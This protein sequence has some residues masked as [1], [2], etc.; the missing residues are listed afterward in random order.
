MDKTQTNQDTSGI[1]LWLITWKAYDAMHANALASIDELG[2]CLSD[3]GI[4]ELLLHK[5]PSTINDLGSKLSLTSGSSTQAVDRLESRGLVRREPSKTDRRAKVVH[6]TA[7]GRQL[8]EESF[9]RHEKDMERACDELTGEER[10]ELIRLLK[11]LGKHAQSLL[12][13]KGP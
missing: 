6:L 3:F 5:G 8:I 10:A 7:E 13:R 1:H 12:A 2:M 4:L 11:K 9:A